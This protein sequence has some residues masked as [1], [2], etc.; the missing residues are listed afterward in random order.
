MHDISY[1]YGFTE[2]A[3]NFQQSNFMRGGSGSDA[4]VINVQSL[5]NVNNA[6]FMCPPDGF[7]AVM[8]LFPFDKSTPYRDSALDNL[9]IMHEYVHGIS[10]RMTG[11]RL[12]AHCMQTVYARGLGE[13]WSDAVAMF[14]NRRGNNG[15]IVERSEGIA[16]YAMNDEIGLRKYL[17]S[18]DFKVN[19]LT[20]KFPRSLMVVTWLNQI[21]VQMPP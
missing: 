5:F 1:M 13:G 17:Y 21:H 10:Q 7:P 14:I 6:N 11:G 12:N 3:G 20:C 8:N 2:K 16:T 18:T 19:P 4:V 9:I 15:S